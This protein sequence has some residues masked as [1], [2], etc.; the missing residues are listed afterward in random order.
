MVEEDYQGL[1]LASLVLRELIA[2][3]KSAGVAR[4]IAEV[5]PANAAMLQVFRRSGHAM[6]SRTQ[7]GVVHV[8]LEV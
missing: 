3:A 7:D 1:G 6:S 8:A 5:L 4:F 2:I